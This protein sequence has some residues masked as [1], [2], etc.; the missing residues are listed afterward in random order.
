MDEEYKLANMKGSAQ[1]LEITYDI[2]KR[3]IYISQPR[4]SRRYLGRALGSLYK[5]IKSEKKRLSEITK[6][7]RK[8]LSNKTQLGKSGEEK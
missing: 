2:L 5:D 7:K 6:I 8:E 1:Q 3:R 4:E